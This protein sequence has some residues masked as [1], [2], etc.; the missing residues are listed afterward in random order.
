MTQHNALEQ[1]L[2][3]RLHEIET[4]ESADSVHAALSGRSIAV[5]AVVCVAIAAASW[6]VAAL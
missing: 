5:F 1:E 4:N 3:R 2:E 6:L